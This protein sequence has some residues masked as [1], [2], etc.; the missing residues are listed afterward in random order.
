MKRFVSLIV[1][2][3][4]LYFVSSCSNEKDEP[5]ARIF[6]G[7][8]AGLPPAESEVGPR[9]SLEPVPGGNLEAGSYSGKSFTTE[10]SLDAAGIYTFTDCEFQQG[11]A[12]VFGGA[13]VTRVVTIDHCLIMT[14]L[15][16]EYGGQT[17]WTIRWSKLSGVNQ[18]LRPNGIVMG[19]YETP[20]PFEVSDSIVENTWK[21]SPE[22]HCE[23]MQSLGGNNMTFIRVRFF[24]P[25]PYIDPAVDEENATGQTAAINHGGGDTLFDACEFMEA[26]AF[27]F[28]IY[29]HGSNVLFRNCRIA[30]GLAGYIY[31]ESPIMAVYENCTDLDTGEPVSLPDKVSH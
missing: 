14:G 29:S 23:A 27:Y 9:I 7:A 13:D 20:T 2:S 25:G 24:T 1:I 19:D 17:D 28:T 18:G 11:F 26:G 31:P 5:A 15:Y 10:V 21:G 8:T 4:L 16:F 6:P 30:R 3:A 12:T 22:S